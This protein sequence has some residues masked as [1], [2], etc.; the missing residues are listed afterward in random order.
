MLDNPANQAAFEQQLMNDK[1]LL[2]RLIN[3]SRQ[4]RQ[5]KGK[6]GEALATPVK[7]S[8]LVVVRDL[9]LPVGEA[10]F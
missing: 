9:P 10:P 1:K 5:I 8:R 3:T 2:R 4:A 7:P 6:R